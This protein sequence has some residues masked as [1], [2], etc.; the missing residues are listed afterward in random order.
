ML[1]IHFTFFFF[2]LM[3]GNIL[4]EWFKKGRLKY[5]RRMTIKIQFSE[6][7]CVNIHGRINFHRVKIGSIMRVSC[8][9]TALYFFLLL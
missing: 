3:K 4:Y 9:D 2:F 8:I 7:F 6:I 1:F 5:E